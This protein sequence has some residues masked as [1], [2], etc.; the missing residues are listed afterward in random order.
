MKFLHIVDC[1]K[2]GCHVAPSVNLECTALHVRHLR[3]NTCNIVD[4]QIK[5][6]RLRN[7]NINI[8]SADRILKVKIF[9]FIIETNRAETNWDRAM[10]CVYRAYEAAISNS[11]AAAHKAAKKHTAN[12]IST[13]AASVT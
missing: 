12:T 5:Y 2:G 1:V 8:V 4:Y 3:I 7:L 13:T 10:Q 11:V 9:L 6:A